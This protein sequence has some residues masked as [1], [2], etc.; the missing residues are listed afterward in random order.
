METRLVSIFDI[1]K[2]KLTYSKIYLVY[3]ETIRSLS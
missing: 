3:A 1:G 2:I